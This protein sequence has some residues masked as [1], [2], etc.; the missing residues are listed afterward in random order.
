LLGAFRNAAGIE[1]H[2]LLDANVQVCGPG[3]GGDS[4]FVAAVQRYPM[5]QPRLLPVTSLTDCRA[6]GLNAINS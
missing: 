3:A 5:P 6:S 2:R 1:Q 4:M